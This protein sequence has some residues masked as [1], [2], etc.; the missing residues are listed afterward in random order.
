MYKSSKTAL[1]VQKGIEQPSQLN[2]DAI[3]K[4]QSNK[5]KL[6]SAED[7]FQGIK[8]G[9]RTILSK[10]ITLVESSL[11]RHQ[12][13]AEEIIELC[14]KEPADQLRITNYELRKKN[15]KSTN[16]KHPASGIRHPVSDIRHPVSSIRIGITGVPGAGKSTFIEVLGKELT[17]AGHKLAVLA[18]DPSSS[19][20][21]G[22]SGHAV[23]R[24]LCA[25]QI[26]HSTGDHQRLRHRAQRRKRELF[27][28]I[29]DRTPREI[30]F[31]LV[32]RNNR[33]LFLCDRIRILRAQPVHQF[34]RLDAQKAI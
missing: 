25:H 15:E 19:R 24:Q 12:E 5:H 8:A 1:N 27:P 3:S 20:S 21:K 29:P 2:V 16:F 4:L 28:G 33:L 23:K 30:N 31:N 7:F 18:I 11:P 17:A 14:L 6:L 34:R 22:S 13:L 26:L 32:S 10:A 9:N